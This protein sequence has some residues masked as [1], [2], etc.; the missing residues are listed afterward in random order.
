MNLGFWFCIVLVPFFLLFGIL[1]AVLKDKSAKFVSGFNSLSKEEQKLYDKAYIARDMRNS[2]FLWSAVMLAGALLSYFLTPY[3][4]IAAYVVWGILFFKDVHF[5]E[6]K[7]F[8][9]Y[10]MK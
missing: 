10:L 3:M 7:A 9:K 1:F 6:H 5:D 4:A 2:C 8:E